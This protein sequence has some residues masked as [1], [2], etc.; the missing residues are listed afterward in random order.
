MKKLYGGGERNCLW[1]IMYKNSNVLGK[2]YGKLVTL[3]QL[4]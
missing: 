3:F 1:K 4:I 2:T